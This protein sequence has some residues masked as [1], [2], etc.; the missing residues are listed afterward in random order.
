MTDTSETSADNVVENVHV[1]A[2]NAFCGPI[3]SSIYRNQQRVIVPAK[4]SFDA[5]SM[6]KDR[7]FDLFIDITCVDYLEYRK[8]KHRYGLVYLLASTMNTDRLTVRTF[9]DDPK[10]TVA[11]VVPL[12]EAANWLER[13]VWDLFL[14]LI[15]I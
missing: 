1:H 5:L 7:G 9:V 6:L 15:H 4:N 2:L 3:E 14:S 13:E 8:A 12:W 10:P 11:S